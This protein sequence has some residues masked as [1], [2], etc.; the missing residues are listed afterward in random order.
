MSEVPLQQDETAQTS[1]TANIDENTN[2]AAVTAQA[3]PPQQDNR[4]VDQ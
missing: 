4:Y 1:S 3:Q 2:A